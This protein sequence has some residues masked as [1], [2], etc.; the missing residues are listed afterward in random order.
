QQRLANGAMSTST[1]EAAAAGDKPAA[2]KVTTLATTKERKTIRNR[3]NFLCR[4]AVRADIRIDFDPRRPA[5]LGNQAACACAGDLHRKDQLHQRR[6]SAGQV[7]K[8]RLPLG[9]R[10]KLARGAQTYSAR[11][12]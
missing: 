4:A 6:R 2:R 7:L 1:P 3:M 8:H 5:S 12:P 9:R 11:A 10:N